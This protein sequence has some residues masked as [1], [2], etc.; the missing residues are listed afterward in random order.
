[1]KPGVM[2]AVIVATVVCISNATRLPATAQSTPEEIAKLIHEC[3][4]RTTAMAGRLYDFSFIETSTDE[5]LDKTGRVKDSESKTYE[6]FPIAM[7]RRARFIYVQIAENGIAFTPEKIEKQRQRAAKDTEEFEKLATAPAPATSDYKSP[8]WT[9]GIKVEKR[10]RLSRTYWYLRPTDFLL[11]NDFMAPRRVNLDGR[12]TILMNFRARPGYVFD[13][14]NVPYPVGIPDYGRAMS[15]LAGRIWIDAG[16]KV[17]A[18][19]EASPAPEAAKSEA[20][21]TP[22]SSAALI[23]EFQRL[24][25]GTWAPNEARYNSY[26]REEVFWQ[27]SMKRSIVYNNF[28]LFKT[29]ADVEKT[30][31]VASPTP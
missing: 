16:D 23:Y 10:S 28:K 7:G 20:S 31:P 1:M 11:S 24:A 13:K 2:I 3:G 26:G 5:V 14:T 21:D 30:Q 17:I 29:T 12:Q 8:W 19:L 15:Q 6:V 25:N 27:T 18:R 4:T 22:N 9:Y